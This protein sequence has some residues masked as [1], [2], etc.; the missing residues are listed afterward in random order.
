MRG[1]VDPSGQQQKVPDS[2]RFMGFKGPM[3]LEKLNELVGSDFGR[4]EGPDAWEGWTKYNPGGDPDVGFKRKQ[5]VGEFEKRLGSGRQGKKKSWIGD[6]N[7]AGDIVEWTENSSGSYV[8]NF[9]EKHKANSTLEFVTTYFWDK[10]KYRA[11]LGEGRR[12][13]N[14]DCEYTF[15]HVARFGIIN[16]I[17]LKVIFHDKSHDKFKTPEHNYPGGPPAPPGQEPNKAT[18]PG[19]WVDWKN[20]Q[21]EY[22]EYHNPSWGPNDTFRKWRYGTDP[23][24]GQPGIIEPKPWQR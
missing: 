18:D 2:H 10:V 23:D 9:Y 12:N 22:E 13:A 3:T 7:K 17:E 24:T 16:E 14:G 19:D 1:G 6:C 4:I 5:K 11:T 21:K 8:E 15:K 20:R